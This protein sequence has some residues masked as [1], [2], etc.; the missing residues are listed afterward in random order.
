[1]VDGGKVMMLVLVSDCGI[2]RANCIKEKDNSGS[3]FFSSSWLRLME[4]RFSLIS[5]DGEHYALQ[6]SRRYIVTLYRKS[7]P[8]K[9]NSLSSIPEHTALQTCSYLALG[10]FHFGHHA[11]WHKSHTRPTQPLFS[12]T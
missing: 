4:W 1:M 12:Q 8:T 7:K 2:Q 11:F 10:I 5:Q 9:V 6:L 3:G